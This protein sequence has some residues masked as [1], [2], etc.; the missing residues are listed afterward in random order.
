MRHATNTTHETQS[1]ASR[2]L[3][4]IRQT[5]A[6]ERIRYLAQ[7]ICDNEPASLK[8]LFVLI[9]ASTAVAIAA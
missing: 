9:I 3:Y 1:T 7:A 5:V 4:R 6:V 2:I 8:P